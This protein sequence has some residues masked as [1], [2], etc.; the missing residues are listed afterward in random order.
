MEIRN[1]SDLLEGFFNP[2][3]ADFILRAT[4]DATSGS[5]Q[6]P[7]NAL[8]AAPW[9][10]GSPAPSG[11][12]TATAASLP[13][14]AQPLRLSLRVA[15]CTASRRGSGRRWPT[16]TS[17]GPMHPGSDARYP[18]AGSSRLHSRPV[19]LPPR[20]RSRTASAAQRGCPP[21]HGHRFV[22]GSALDLPTRPSMHNAERL[23]S[24]GLDSFGPLRNP[25]LAP[26]YRQSVHLALGYVI[27]KRSRSK[28]QFCQSSQCTGPLPEASL[29][30][31]ASA[32]TDMSGQIDQ[33]LAIDLEQRDLLAL[34]IFVRQPLK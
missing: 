30:R 5:S 8:A 2:T 28:I 32:R 17:Q 25:Q 13:L 4:F 7:T 24:R 11:C 18:R 1:Y 23:Y 3:L 9:R 21:P 19:R 26:G 10:S 20:A 33:R 12:V 14:T 34:V 16:H 27:R 22:P 6:P 29:Q 15:Y 31:D